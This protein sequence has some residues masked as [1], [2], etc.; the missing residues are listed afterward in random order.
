[1]R[2]GCVCVFVLVSALFFWRVPRTVRVCARVWCVFARI[3]FFPVCSR[4]HSRLVCVL[5]VSV[6]ARAFCLCVFL[7]C[8]R[9]VRMCVVCAFERMCLFVCDVYYVYMVVCEC[10]LFSFARVRVVRVCVL[11]CV[12]SF[13]LTSARVRMLCVCVC[14]CERGFCVLLC[15]RAL[16]V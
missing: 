16:Y 12:D 7:V 1:M 6:R 14:V 15:A 3:L 10:T 8:S 2:S 11:C 9:A 4:S 5:C 13:F